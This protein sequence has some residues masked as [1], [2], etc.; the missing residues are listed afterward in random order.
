MVEIIIYLQKNIYIQRALS[1]SYKILIETFGVQASLN[2]DTKI[3]EYKDTSI[4]GNKYLKIQGYKDKRIQ[5][6][7]DSKIKWYKYIRIQEFR[8]K[9]I[10][11]PCIIISQYLYILVSFYPTILIISQNPYI[12]INIVIMTSL[13]KDTKINVFH[14]TMCSTP[15]MKVPDLS[16]TDSCTFMNCILFSGSSSLH[17]MSSMT[18]SSTSSSQHHC[19]N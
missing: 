2:K 17:P 7:E 3:K 10:Q 8:D 14:N 12:V 15:R 5:G 19:K 18:S 1:V 6:Y 13:N 4:R 11:Y 9:G 16:L